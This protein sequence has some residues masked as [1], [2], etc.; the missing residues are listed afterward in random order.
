VPIN[1][2]LAETQSI[3]EKIL[4]RRALEH[5]L[6]GH[7]L[8]TA[9]EISEALKPEYCCPECAATSGRIWPRDYRT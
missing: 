4:F 2:D 1:Y 9:I 8:E 5:Q 7:T 3:I 6:E